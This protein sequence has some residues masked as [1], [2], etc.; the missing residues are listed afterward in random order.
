MS[1]KIKV[2]I[3]DDHP[4]IADSYENILKD[5]E[6]GDLKLFI[7]KRRNIEE[8]YQS[9]EISKAQNSPY[10]FIF[11]DISLPVAETLGIFSGDELGVKIR[12]IS[13]ESKIVVMTMHNENHRLYNI[14][15]TINPEAFLIKSDVSPEDLKI[16]FKDLLD[17]RI[18]Y[19]QTIRLLLRKQIVQDVA[20]DNNDRSI[21]YHLSKGVRTKE[22]EDIVPLS[23]A[24]IEKR[25]KNMREV[26]GLDKGGDLALIE[27]ARQLGFL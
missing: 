1:K 16:A 4:I 14:L 13:P 7:E 3:I 26:F 20:L 9:I 15:R 11:L 23:L 24:A 22:L 18:H 21:L 8:A 6:D 25:K 12:E 10:H 17:D 27:K 19:S 2:L 5:M